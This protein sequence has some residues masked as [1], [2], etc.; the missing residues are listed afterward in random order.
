MLNV[1]IKFLILF[2]LLAALQLSAQPGIK[3]GITISGLQS[4]TKDFTPFL[5]YEISW[6]QYETSNPV[7]GLQIGAF[8]TFNLSDAF[9]F[10]PELYFIQRGYQFDQTPLY[11]TNYS[12]HI[13]YLELPALFEYNLPLD[14]G[15]NPKIIVGPFAALKLSSDKQIRISNEEINGNVSSVNNLDYGLVF[16][17]NTEFTAWDGE[18]IF[19]LRINW[20]FANVM[21]QPDEFISISDDLGTV[22]T[23]AVTL[24]TGY[25]FNL[26]W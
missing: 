8:Y 19:D 9:K 2:F 14:W 7:F 13:N 5:G 20:G 25:R 23:R 1:A 6:L 21:T 17:I 24:M 4:S 18:L 16:G 22:K 15:F 26:D 12:L 10:Q 11:N 3:G